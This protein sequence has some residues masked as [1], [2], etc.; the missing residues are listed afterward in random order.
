MK[1]FS[2]WQR[3][4][5]AVGLGI[6][7]FGLAMAFFNG[8]GFFRWL[9]DDQINPVFWGAEALP[10]GTEAFRSWIYGVLG[11]TIAGWGCTIVFIA[12]HPFKNREKWAWDAVLVG[13]LVWFVVDTSLSWYFAVYFNALF[14]AVLFILVM[15]PLAFS[16]KHFV[17][18]PA[19]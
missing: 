18:S 7:L 1:G 17:N 16:R 13:V 12:R 5:F 8:T 2:F 11:A 19:P 4:L 14:N 10:V 6:A 15:F 9:F 3:W